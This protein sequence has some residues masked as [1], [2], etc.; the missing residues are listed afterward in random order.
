MGHK[1]EFLRIASQEESTPN[2]KSAQ[3]LDLATFT[4]TISLDMTTFLY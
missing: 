4:K 1:H 3:I 2:N